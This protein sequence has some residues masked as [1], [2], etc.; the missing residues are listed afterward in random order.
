MLVARDSTVKA[1]VA[2]LRGRDARPYGIFAAVQ[3]AGALVGGATAGAL[4]QYPGGG[5]VV[6]VVATRCVALLSLVPALRR[7]RGS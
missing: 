7:S 4:Y 3:G 2:D 6:G 5:L 1:F